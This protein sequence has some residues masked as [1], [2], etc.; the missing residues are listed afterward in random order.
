[1]DEYIRNEMEDRKEKALKRLL[2]ILQ[3][4][5]NIVQL[6]VEGYLEDLPSAIT[7]AE[8]YGFESMDFFAID[9]QYESFRDE[10]MKE[11]ENLAFEEAYDRS[12]DRHEFR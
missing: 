2:S 12:C 6:L 11:I 5:E 10:F 1:M 9:G 8:E 7:I 4:E 3:K